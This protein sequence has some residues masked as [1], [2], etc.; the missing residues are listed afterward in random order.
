MRNETRELPFTLRELRDAIPAACFRP[1]TA[2]S[3]LHLAVDL[4][5][6]GALYLASF[7][8]TGTLWLLP[9]VFLQGTLFWALFL[10][11]HD[12]GHGAFSRRRGWNEWVGHAVHT[13]LLVPYH[14]W[15]LSH[16]A[17]HRHTGDVE[18]DEAWPP[19]TRRELRALPPLSRFMRLRG[20]L[21]VF[22]LYLLRN[23]PGR[24]GSH[25]D[26][27]GPLFPDA[28]R[29]GVRRSVLLCG[30]MAAALAAAGWRFGAS[31]LLQY[32]LAPY[33]V[34]AVWIALVTFLQHTAPDVPW[35]RGAGWSHLR[36]ALST[37][38]RSY[39]PFERLHHD[40]GSH[41][42]HH[43]F[44]RIPHYR[45]RE[46][47]AA[48]DPILAGRR[49]RAR[50]PIVRALWQAATRCQTIPEEG[51][52][53]FYEPLAGPPAPAPAGEWIPP[54]RAGESPATR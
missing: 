10:I 15:R 30:A 51:E 2:R 14:A 28:G 5:L 37:V 38:D 48:I 1:S 11:G 6:L 4:G 54:G 17:H 39:G 43:L 21:L 44:P 20:F 7:H 25:F 53:V 13:P 29:A 36:G 9:I 16:R 31:A 41:V 3:L 34:F 24:A 8:A 42:V 27:K 35:Y 40:V 52:R 22:P 49:R 45:L 33:L 19:L 32:W 47:T 46:A 50:E 12:C 18:R 26:A 23:G